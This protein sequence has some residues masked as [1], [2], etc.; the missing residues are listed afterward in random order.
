MI[1]EH[2]GANGYLLT[3][4]RHKLNH[5][6]DESTGVSR[7]HLYFV[8]SQVLN[9]FMTYFTGTGYTAKAGC[10]QTTRITTK[11]EQVV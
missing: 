7:I 1:D 11:R 2:I 8:L 3:A 4:W 6:D 10:Y 5:I 9:Y